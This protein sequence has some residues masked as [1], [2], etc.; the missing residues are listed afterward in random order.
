[1]V[2]QFLLLSLAAVPALALGQTAPRAGKLIEQGVTIGPEGPVAVSRGEQATEPGEN[3]QPPRND[4]PWLYRLTITPAAEPI[5]ALKYRFDVPP[6]EQK[7]GNS[8]TLYYRALVR[9][10]EESSE[11]R[12]AFDDFHTDFHGVPLDEFP[13]EKAREILAR[14]RSIFDELERATVRDK[15]DWNWRL[16]E[17]NGTEA[18][19]FRLEEVQ[20][21]RHFSRML[22]L[23]ARLEIA[24]GRFDEATKTLR[25]GY[26]LARAVAEPPFIINAL[27]GIAI[28]SIMDT[29]VLDWINTPGSPNVYWAVS[30]LPDPRVDMRPAL[31]YDLGFAFRFAPWLK[32]A[33]A[34]DVPPTVWRNRFVRLMSDFSDV[35]DLVG[36]PLN[37]SHALLTGLALRSYPAAKQALVEEQGYSVEDVD[38]MPVGQVLAIRQLFVNRTIADELLKTELVPS[39]AAADVGERADESLK[40]RSLLLRPGLGKEPIPLMAL[41]APATRQAAQA[42]WRLTTKFAGLRAIEAIRMHAAVTGKL[43]QSLDEITVVPVPDNPTTGEPFSYRIEEKKAVLD[44]AV[45]G[46]HPSGDWRIELTLE[47]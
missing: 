21:A 28:C 40:E 15:T 13:V 9:L 41:L 32:T 33:A 45:R 8:A 26:H 42:E 16:E 14:Y 39:E 47:K 17:L 2:K 10:G 19:S 6:M 36:G 25:V 35:G 18:I 20:Q 11:S 34:D 4:Q 7:P 37:P 27:V 38:A 3:P 12:R 24:E 29:V 5:P 1:M 22:Q 23:K 30:A 46:G 31:E 43:P 44:I